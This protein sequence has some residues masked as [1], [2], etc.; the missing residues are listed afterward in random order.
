MFQFRVRTIQHSDII[1]SFRISILIK[2]PLFT[3]AMSAETA[4]FIY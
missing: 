1:V 3:S 4:C 2:K